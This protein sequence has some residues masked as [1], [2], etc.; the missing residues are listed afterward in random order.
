MG[1]QDEMF[2][3]ELK[4]ERFSLVREVIMGYSGHGLGALSQHP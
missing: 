3:Y 2:S 1:L 4:P